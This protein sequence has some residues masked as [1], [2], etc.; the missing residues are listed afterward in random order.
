MP[1]RKGDFGRLVLRIA[2]LDCNVSPHK[3]LL[4]TD[5]AS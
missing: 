4:D 1:D 3:K 5:R 2:R